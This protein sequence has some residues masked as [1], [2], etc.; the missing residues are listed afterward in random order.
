MAEL[1][2]LFGHMSHVQDQL[3]TRILFH[4]VSSVI[5]IDKWSVIDESLITGGTTSKL[6]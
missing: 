2:T 4:N 5:G 3:S 6:G 1:L